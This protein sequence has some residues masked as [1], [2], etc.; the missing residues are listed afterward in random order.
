M[1]S[2]VAI[3]GVP[4]VAKEYAYVIEL[5]EAKHALLDNPRYNLLRRFLTKRG[6]IE[7]GGLCW[8]ETICE[9]KNLPERRGNIYIRLRR[10]ALALQFRL[11]AA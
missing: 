4:V 7:R 10:P 6:W 8:I 11:E 2:T 1:R 5:E 9:E 3:G